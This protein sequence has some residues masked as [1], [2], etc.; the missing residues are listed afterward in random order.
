[1][2]QPQPVNQNQLPYNK[3]VY[4]AYTAIYKNAKQLLSTLEREEMRYTLE[5]EDKTPIK[6]GTIIHELI[7]PLLYL[8]IECHPSNSYAI[9]YGFEQVSAINQY[10]K[11]TSLFIRSI[12]KFTSKDN[13]QV[14]IEDCIRTD[15][16]I[17]CSDMYEYVEENSKH[18]TFKLVQH[19]T[20]PARRKQM[21]AV[22]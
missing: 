16:C 18:H 3:A 15:W 20:K 5:R 4:L 1:M 21:Q 7:S 2:K 10:S 22:A 9:H 13:T 14:N 19:K 17:T 8:R 11:L 6:I 12:Y